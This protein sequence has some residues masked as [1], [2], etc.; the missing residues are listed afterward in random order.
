MFLVRRSQM[1]LLP[2]AERDGR[3]NPSRTILRG[4]LFEHRNRGQLLSL[5]EF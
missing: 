5:H 2:K 3:D 4:A 1:A